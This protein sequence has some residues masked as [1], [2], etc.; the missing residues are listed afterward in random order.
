MWTLHQ[1][2]AN[3]LPLIGRISFLANFNFVANL[4]PLANACL[5]CERLS[6]ASCSLVTNQIVALSS[7]DLRSLVTNCARWRLKTKKYLRSS[8]SIKFKNFF[9]NFS[10]FCFRRWRIY[11]KKEAAIDLTCL[12]DTTVLWDVVFLSFN[13]IYYVV[14]IWLRKQEFSLPTRVRQIVFAVWRRL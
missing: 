3:R 9:V 2:L 11:F 14:K 8:S 7:R 5:T 6:N 13:L 10:L 1:Q 4:S 12:Y